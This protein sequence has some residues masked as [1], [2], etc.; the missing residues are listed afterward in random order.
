MLQVNKHTHTHIY[1]IK[2]ICVH[3]IFKKIDVE[4]LNIF[5]A[6]IPISQLLN[7]SDLDKVNHAITWSSVNI[8]CSLDAA[9]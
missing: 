7:Q 3:T 9:I 8:L 1:K 4:T 5:K 2:R 6:M